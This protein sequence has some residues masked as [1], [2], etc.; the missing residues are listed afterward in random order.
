[1]KSKSGFSGR[2]LVVSG[3]HSSVG[4]SSIASGLMRLLKRRGLE[5]KPFKVG[6]DYIDPGHHQR[7]CGQPSYNLDTFMCTPRYVRNIFADKMGDGGVAVVE[8]V[9]GLYDGAY[10]A[11]PLGST[12]E[13]AKLLDLPVLLVI[14]PTA[15]ARSA[16]ALVNGFL[17]FDPE[18]RFI[19]VIANRVNS[20]SH[21]QILKEAIQHHTSARFLGYLPSIPDLEIPSRHLGLFLGDE[22]KDTLYDRWAD[23]LER[24]I[25]IGAISNHIQIKNNRR[26]KNLENLPARWR[27]K[28]AKGNFTVGIA[29]DEAFQFIYPDTLDMFQHFGGEIFYFSP[30]HDKT[31]PKNIDWIYLPGGYPELHAK[32]LSANKSLLKDVR[33]FGKS[34]KPIVGEC[35]GMMYLGQSITDEPGKKYPMTGLFNFSTTLQEKKM[36]L[37]YR[38][39]T[40]RTPGKPAKTFTLK[41]HEFHYS[42]FAYNNE[43][44]RMVQN[45]KGKG[46]GVRDGYRFKNCFALYSHI[47]WGSSPDWLKYLLRVMGKEVQRKIS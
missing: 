5:V 4:K 20:E 25:D 44:T 22:Q 33:N 13:I 11:K 24:Y 18:V 7:A 1:M 31:L 10:P 2:G 21:A 42:R 14:E 36:T 3:T 17:N 38:Q 30:L 26:I 16:A 41:G 23:H 29:K 46:F 39:L 32:K 34:G 6:P 8:G 35:G 15:M 43:R 19:G 12:A 47:Y 45:K 28:P 40:Y 37:G 27:S 9:M